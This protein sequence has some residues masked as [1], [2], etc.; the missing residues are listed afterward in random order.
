MDNEIRVYSHA[1]RRIYNAFYMETL[2]VNKKE[3][4]ENHRG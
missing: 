2:Y 3:K 1:R 4:K